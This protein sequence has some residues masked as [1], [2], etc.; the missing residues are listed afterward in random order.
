MQIYPGNFLA[1]RVSADIACN[2][3]QEIASVKENHKIMG[4]LWI[5]HHNM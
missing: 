1:N 3:S 5:T 2:I 4:S